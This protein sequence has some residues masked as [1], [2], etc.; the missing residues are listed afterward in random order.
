MTLVSLLLLAWLPALTTLPP[1]DRDES[2]FA[3]A[4][5]QML[6]TGDYVDIRFGS[7]PRYN[8]P[9]GIYWLQSLSATV[10][11]PALR[12]RIWVYRIPSL[13]G[14]L[15]SA[16]FL[17][18]LA[19]S[20][21]SRETALFAALLLGTT[22]LLTTESVI[23]TTDATLLATTIAA[24]SVL[25]KSYLA[26]REKSEPPSFYLV[27]VGWVA[28]GVGVLLK[29]PVILA[30]L[31][32]TALAL[33]VADRD[34]TWLRATRPLRGTAL[35]LAL[36]APW[37]IAIGFASHG[38]FYQQSLGHDF[39][40]KLMEGKESHG[41]PPGYYLIETII[42]FWP[43][44]LLLIPAAASAIERRR[45]PVVRFLLAWS[46]SVWIL[47]EL[48]PTKLPHYVLPAYPAFALLCALWATQQDQSEGEGTISR[49]GSVV[50]FMIGAAAFAG[51]CLYLPVRFGG[52]LSV[53]LLTGAA[54][55]SLFACAASILFLRNRVERAMG[56]A[57]VSAVSFFVT[58]GS[59]VVPQLRDLWLSPRA[60]HLVIANKIAGDPP[61]ILVGY[62]EPSL[63]FFLGPDTR[64]A[65][66]AQA[67][68]AVAGGGIALVERR[69]APVF[70]KALGSAGAIARPLGKVRG[71]DYSIGREEDVTLYRVIPARH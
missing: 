44:T 48:V 34:F 62:V 67:A 11:G 24:Q 42:A 29:G 39:A 57:F 43:A 15:L 19:R 1:L 64:I 50:L 8:K 3:E 9:I 68:G 22:L 10:A 40:A 14:G 13:L 30:A 16:V 38:A 36:V 31:A 17:Y 63:V 7:G 33:S 20:I 35:A 61:P 52:A 32:V 4:S 21:A 65:P 60:A 18:G 47:V 66:P 26:A 2:R 23:A 56:A 5:R 69:A 55:G 70:L 71:L 41:A 12:D 6:E 45:E 58:L 51:A 27:L 46:A 25:L 53:P 37:A 28:V 54:I 49:I 59:M